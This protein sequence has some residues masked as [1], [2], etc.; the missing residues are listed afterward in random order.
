M[1]L[2]GGF[3]DTYLKLNAD[4]EEQLRREISVLAPDEKET[5]MQIT[6]SWELRGMHR[7]KRELVV[8]MLRHRFGEVSK[9]IETNIDS[10]EDSQIDDFGEALLSFTSLADA[11]AWLLQHAD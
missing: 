1:Q 9:E 8:K 3:V 4:E 11:E 5:V 10:L 6:T 2:I 7:G